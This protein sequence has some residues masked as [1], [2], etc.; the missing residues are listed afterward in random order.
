MWFAPH[1]LTGSGADEEDGFD[2]QPGHR[3]VKGCGVGLLKK[4]ETG[5]PSMGILEVWFEGQ[6]TL[7]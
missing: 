5:I 4:N 2:L 3:M 6:C 7:S 1:E